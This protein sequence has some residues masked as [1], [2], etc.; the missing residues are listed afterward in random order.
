MQVYSRIVRPWRAGTTDGSLWSLKGAARM[1]RNTFR[2]LEPR[3]PAPRGWSTGAV[4]DRLSAVQELVDRKTSSTATAQRMRSAASLRYLLRCPGSNSRLAYL[5]RHG[6]ICG[7]FM[8]NRI[9]AQCRIVDIYV[10]SDQHDDWQS[11]YTLALLTAMDDN[12]TGEVIA[13][14]SLP[15][16]GGILTA[17]GMRLLRQKPVLLFER[18]GGQRVDLPLS[19]QLAD[20]DAFCY[21]QD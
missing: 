12:E 11:A 21:P 2:S 1:V 4:D 8:L 20:S 6:A 19:L 9:D 17:C 18:A 10:D 7:Y 3:R 5:A 14:T 15:Q 13:A 16:L